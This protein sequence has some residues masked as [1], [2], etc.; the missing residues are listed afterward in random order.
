MSK[1]YNKA[2]YV[3]WPDYE[4]INKAI[5]SGVN[6]LIIAM[7]NPRPDMEQKKYFGTYEENVETL[8]HYRNAKV[9]LILMPA[10]WQPWYP[11]PKEHC[12]ILGHKFYLKTPCPTDNYHID[13]VTEYPLKLY[14]EGLC[15]GLF[16]DFEDYGAHD[17][18]ERL[19]YFDEWNEDKYRCMCHRCIGFDEREQRDILYEK[20]WNKLDDAKVKINGEYNYTDPLMWDA[21][22]HEQWFVNAH[23]YKDWS[24]IKRIWKYTFPNRWFRKT[25]I[26]NITC[27]QWLEQFTSKESLEHLEKIGKSASVDGY[28]LYPQMRMSK[29]C[30]WILDPDNPWSK[31]STKDL[32]CTSLIDSNIHGADPDY[33]LKLKVLNNEIIKYRNGWWF[34]IKR[35]LVMWFMR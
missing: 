11:L 29:N 9:K 32:K 14:K 25:K 18:P 35:K 13:W 27:G 34:S 23:T 8:T 22:P 15:D 28:W 20:I 2:M 5:D 16:W 3:L 7:Y 17:D 26:E 4:Y 19:K 12:F 10:W 21:F 6:T 30:P 24:V 1:K 33:F 31:T